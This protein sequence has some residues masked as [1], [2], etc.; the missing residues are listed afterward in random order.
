[1]DEAF[2]FD[3]QETHNVYLNHAQFPGSLMVK[4][5]PI[6]FKLWLDVDR[7]LKMVPL[8]GLGSIICSR[9]RSK[10]SA[11]AL[12]GISLT[13]YWSLYENSLS[14]DHIH[15]RCYEWNIM[16]K[17]AINGNILIIKQLTVAG[18]CLL[19]HLELQICRMRRVSIIDHHQYK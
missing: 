19:G 6:H 15:L 9:S 4:A 5:N 3:I 17:E 18:K 14:V 10:I 16:F 8:P 1:M 13:I 12:K 11:Y 2:L 7:H